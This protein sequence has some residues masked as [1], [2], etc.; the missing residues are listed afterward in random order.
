MFTRSK[1]GSP[2]APSPLVTEISPAVP[3]KILGTTVPL[4]GKAA[5]PAP[6]TLANDK[7]SPFRLIVGFPA[8]PSPLLMAIPEPLT[9]IVLGVMVLASVFTAKPSPAAFNE[10]AAPCKDRLMVDC[11]PLSVT[12]IPKVLESAL[13]FGK[14]GS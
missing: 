11:G 13:L 9:A 8:C 7:T 4:F 12:P 14:V 2:A 1:T 10:A 3:V 5:I 6:D